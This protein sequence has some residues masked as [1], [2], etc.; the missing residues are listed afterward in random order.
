MRVAVINPPF[1]NGRFSRPSRSPAINK[2]GTLYW[3]FWLAHAVG[4]LESSG[5]DVLF[6]DCPATGTDTGE[7]IRRV[8]DFAPR[9]IVVD[10]STPSIVS[11]LRVVAALRRGIAGLRDRPFLVLVGTHVSALPGET[12][13]E[14]EPPSAVA[15]GEYDLTLPEL[16]EAL[17]DGRDPA[18]I[19]GLMLRRDRGDERVRTP[20]RSPVEDLD[21][22]PMLADVYRRHLHPE[23][24]F[25]AAARFPS[26]MT[27]TSRGCPFGCS[28]CLWPHLLHGNRFR[29]RSPGHVAREFRLFEEYFPQV[30]EVVIEDDTF[31]VSDERVQ[32]VSDALIE[33]G[34][35][36][37][38]TANVRATLSLESMR[39]MRTAG[40]RLLIVGYESG[41][42]EVLDRVGKGIRV[43]QSYEFAR[44]A[45]KAGLLVHGCFMAGN[46]GETRD[47]LEETLRMAI[48]LRPDTAQFFP[49]MVYPGTPDYDRLMESGDIRAE[50][51]T[52]WL[53]P[54]G[55]HNC[56]VDLPGIAAE[57]LV[58]WCNYARRR[59]YLRPSYLAYKLLQTIAHPLTEG[60]RTF[61]SF[62]TFR[63][64]LFRG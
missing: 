58:S 51:Y 8:A 2:S 16:A 6:V 60:R 7:M 28:F 59:F 45:R 43:E 55:L 11:D 56:V 3:P 36:L 31:A 34:N 33:S 40:C 5:H 32:L 12:L 49:L 23:D 35:T 62:R 4:T 41:S 10:T 52:D 53:T 29:A 47:T 26:V 22:L 46:N 57:E 17:E 30:R 42:Q 27:I 24:Y 25:F 61:K 15:I 54:E 19:A 64:H 1:M 20:Q 9:L 63:R 38:W 37:P 39:R 14:L 50:S 48:R 13:E 21:T 44:N 18:G